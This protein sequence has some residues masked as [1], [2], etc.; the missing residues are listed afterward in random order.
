MNGSTDSRMNGATTSR[1]ENRE[2]WRL[3]ERAAEEMFLSGIATRDEARERAGLPATG[4]E[5][6]GEFVERAQGNLTQ[7]RGDAEE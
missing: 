6:G 1:A 7:R 5:R 2:R 4:G 3:K